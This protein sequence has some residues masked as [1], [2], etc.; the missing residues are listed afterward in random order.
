MV[1]K[2]IHS[3][4]EIRIMMSSHKIAVKVE[5]SY[6]EGIY[7]VSCMITSWIYPQT[8]NQVASFYIKEVNIRRAINS[9]LPKH[10]E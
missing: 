10:V 2:Q 1:R 9:T 7:P 8:K 5:T 6:L 3:R 4:D